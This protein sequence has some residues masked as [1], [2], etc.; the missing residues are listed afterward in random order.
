MTA[1][2]RHLEHVAVAL[3]AE[4]VAV[5]QLVREREHVERRLEV[6]DRVVQVDRLDGIPADEVDDVERLAEPQQFAERGPVA[7][8]PDAIEVDDVGWAADRPDATDRRRS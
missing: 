2:A 1:D 8:T 5:Q 7:R 6:T 3:A 4:A